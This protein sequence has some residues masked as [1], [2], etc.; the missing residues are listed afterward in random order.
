MSNFKSPDRILYGI[1]TYETQKLYL[2]TFN[3][4]CYLFL[5]YS[6]LILNIISFFFFCLLPQLPSEV[7]TFHFWGI[8][9]WGFCFSW[10]LIFKSSVC[11]ETPLFKVVDIFLCL[12]ALM[13]LSMQID[14]YLIL[15]LCRKKSLWTLGLFI[16]SLTAFKLKTTSL[17]KY[18]ILFYILFHYGLHFYI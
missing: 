13:L 16:S 15:L 18:Q 17:S 6:F 7:E 12:Y 1:L 8:F 4:K 11:V 9:L 2:I 3:I 10:R 14:I 5:I